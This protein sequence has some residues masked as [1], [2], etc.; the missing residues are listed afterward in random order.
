MLIERVVQ[1]LLE[2]LEVDYYVNKE[3]L[4]S[5]V[6]QNHSEALVMIRKKDQGR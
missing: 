2:V 4:D 1:N 5:Q 3:F 6:F